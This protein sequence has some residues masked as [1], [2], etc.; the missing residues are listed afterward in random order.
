MYALFPFGN[1][2][3]MVKPLGSKK[4]CVWSIPS[5]MIPILI[6]FPAVAKLGPQ[7]AEAPIRSTSGPAAAAWVTVVRATR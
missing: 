3:G 2:A 5:S 6:P 4:G 1:P 7:R